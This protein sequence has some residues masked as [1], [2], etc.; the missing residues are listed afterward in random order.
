MRSNGRL[1]SWSLCRRRHA[2]VASA[3]KDVVAYRGGRELAKKIFWSWRSDTDPR[4]TRN[5][6]REA[7]AMAL[8]KIGSDFEEADRTEIDQD[9][10][11]VAG[12]PDIV[13]S[14]LEKIDAASVFVGDATPAIR[15]PGS[16]KIFLNPNVMIEYGQKWPVEPAGDTCVEY[17]IRRCPTGR[18]ALRPARPAR[19]D[20]LQ[21]RRGGEPGGLP[22]STPLGRRGTRASREV[23]ARY[24]P[25]CAG[26]STPMAGRHRGWPCMGRLRPA[27]HDQSA[28]LVEREGDAAR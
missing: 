18:S 10:K 25:R 1:P 21:P 14:I 11:D 17:G 19:A 28:G 23:G 20:Q 16:G 7:L 15:C 26:A 8:E 13:A 22:E 5:L 24:S 12:T 3:A 4:V 2:L 9:T 27:A 6:I